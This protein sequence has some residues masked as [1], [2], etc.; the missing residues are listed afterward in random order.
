MAG[1]GPAPP[2]E[3]PRFHVESER[4]PRRRNHE[5][6]E[7]LSPALRHRPVS[8]VAEPCRS[9]WSPRCSRSAGS[10][11][12]RSSSCGPGRALPQ[13]QR[14]RLTRRRGLTLRPGTRHAP[15][16]GDGHDQARPSHPRALQADRP[17]D[18]CCAPS[19]AGRRA[20]APSTSCSSTRW[21]SCSLRQSAP[22][23][24][25]PRPFSNRAP[26][27]LRTSVL[28]NRAPRRLNRFSRR[29]RQAQQPRGAFSNRAPRRP[30]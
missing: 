25:S 24:A 14:D 11:P 1:R 27:L 17:A 28:S 13:R 8:E 2:A 26:R 29:G 6:R 12:T 20:S 18:R 4:T 15:R 9:R 30:S 16:T 7:R 19:G 21:Q 5:R 22:A 10:R 3:A 23:L